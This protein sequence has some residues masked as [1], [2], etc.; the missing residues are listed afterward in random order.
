[1][2]ALHYGITYGSIANASIRDKILAKTNNIIEITRKRSVDEGI[3]FEEIIVSDNIGSAITTYVDTN[4]FHTIVRGS[5]GLS[6]VRQA[7]LGSVANHVIHT[8]KTP[9]LVVK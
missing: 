5:N 8:S 3:H 9:V 2:F 7:F 4:E 1:M 6:M